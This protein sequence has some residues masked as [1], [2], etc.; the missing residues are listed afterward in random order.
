MAKDERGIN[1]YV[2]GNPQ[3]TQENLA[4]VEGTLATLDIIIEELGGSNVSSSEDSG[5]DEQV[6][7]V[8]GSE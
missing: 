6:W 2:R 4:E 7:G 5:D 1:S 8:S 3:L